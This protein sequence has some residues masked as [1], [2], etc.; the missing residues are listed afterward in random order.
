MSTDVLSDVLRS[1]RVAGSVY[2]CDRLDVPWRK[3]FVDMAT[4]S[5]HQVRRG[6]ARVVCDEGEVLLGAGELVFLAPGRDHVLEG[7]G[8]DG[9][10]PSA[11]AAD[12]S[13]TVLL[14]GYCSFDAE[15]DSPLGSLFPAMSVIRRRELGAHSALVGIL[16]QLGAEYLSGRPG[17]GL[18]VERL[19]E[20][21]VVELIRMDFGRDGRGGLLAAMSDRVIARALQR[22]HARP[23]LSWTLEWLGHE[24]GLSR[25]AFA[26]RFRELVG[27][28]MFDYLTRL[29]MQRARELLR[30]TALPLHEIAARVGYDSDLA[31]TRTFR[32]RVGTT[33]VAWRKSARA[34]HGTSS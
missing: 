30:D 1:L 23:E 33:P 15:A 34:E 16:E 9:T 28:P 13:G 26:A 14:C 2:F 20:V 24:V 4:A 12:E 7:V 22:L 32:K 8:A 25:A 11:E 27:L 6:C 21:L 3:E 31:F 29:R 17:S 10:D 19:T 18:V 5:F